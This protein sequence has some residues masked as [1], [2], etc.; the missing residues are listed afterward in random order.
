MITVVRKQ[1]FWPGM[2]KEIVDYIARCLECQQVKEE[3]K[4]PTGLLQPLSIPEWK[5]EVIN[6]EFITGFPKT[7]RTT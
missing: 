1:Y 7:V 4:H 6:M 2:K 3:H 5:W